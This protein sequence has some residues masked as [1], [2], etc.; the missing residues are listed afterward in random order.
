MTF[1]LKVGIQSR[2][3]VNNEASEVRIR[4]VRIRLPRRPSNAGSDAATSF[5]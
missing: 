1:G 5:S 3:C 4:E 2:L